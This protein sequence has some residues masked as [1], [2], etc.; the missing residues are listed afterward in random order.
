M[1]SPWRRLRSNWLPEARIATKWRSARWTPASNVAMRLASTPKAARR[2]ARPTMLFTDS[3]RT[4]C[5]SPE[6][7]QC[8]RPAR[9]PRK[10][11][12]QENTRA[13]RL[14]YEAANSP[15]GSRLAQRRC[16][17]SRTVEQVRQGCERPVEGARTR[18]IPIALIQDEFNIGPGHLLNTGVLRDDCLIVKRQACAK[19]V[20]VCQECQTR[21]RG[22]RDAVPPPALSSCS[23]LRYVGR[24]R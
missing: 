11:T 2:S 15:N 8:G 5:S 10:A 24:A 22:Q 23:G 14:S 6:C 4:G 17:G 3:V 18:S 9:I 20:R 1:P 21:K 13:R 12:D 16:A 7:G 19:G